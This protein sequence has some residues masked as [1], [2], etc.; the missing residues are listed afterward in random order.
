MG[1]LK[2]TEASKLRSGQSL[3]QGGLAQDFG[4]HRT[5]DSIEHKYTY[6]SGAGSYFSPPREA[7]SS[8]IIPSP[9]MPIQSS[10]SSCFFPEPRILCAQTGTGDSRFEINFAGIPP[11][12]SF[13]GMSFVTTAFAPTIAPSPIDTGEAI[14]TL[15]PIKTSLPIETLPS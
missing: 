6:P 8:H 3:P 15:M 11:H 2:L 5:A 13:A 10:S 1:I 4:R 12:T 7:S 14:T 9:A